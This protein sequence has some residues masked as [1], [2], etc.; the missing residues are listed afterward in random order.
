MLEKESWK[1][2]DVEMFGLDQ[3]TISGHRNLTSCQKREPVTVASALS[4]RSLCQAEG[5]R[6]ERQRGSE[7]AKLVQ[8]EP[9]GESAP[10][11]STEAS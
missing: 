11:Q 6:G 4:R 1:L 5:W 9:S 2:R 3:G 10:I 8:V 7:G